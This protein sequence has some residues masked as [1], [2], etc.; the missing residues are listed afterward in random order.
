[1]LRYGR[2]LDKSHG[3]R[4]LHVAG[5][6]CFAAGSCD[7]KN[8]IGQQ[9]SHFQFD[10][11]THPTDFSDIEPF[12]ELYNPNVLV[13]PLLRAG[14]DSA[15]SDQA[16][17]VTSS[18]QDANAGRSSDSFLST[19]PYSESLPPPY[20]T[21]IAPTTFFSKQLHSYPNASQSQQPLAAVSEPSCITFSPQGLYYGPVPGGKFTQSFPVQDLEQSTEAAPQL[22][23]ETAHQFNYSLPGMSE[24]NAESS[25]TLDSAPSE[26][27]A[28]AAAPILLPLSPSAL[29]PT[30]SGF[31]NGSSPRKHRYRCS[32]HGCPYSCHLRKDLDKHQFKHVK[33]DRSRCYKCPNEGCEQVFPRK[34]N[35]QRHARTTCAFR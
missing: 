2:Y 30:S 34:D 11:W 18:R 14:S 5:A 28:E 13:S 9:S 35:C 12:S 15:S 3:G 31:K 24:S 21:N 32:W 22:S 6:A 23:Y 25:D 1:L 19:S 4:L 17:S 16:Q 26:S 7:D 8:P 27:P 10:P 33:P 29:P 20:F